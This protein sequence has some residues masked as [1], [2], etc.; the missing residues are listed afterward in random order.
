MAKTSKVVQEEISRWSKEIKRGA[1]TLAI[2]ALLVRG[3]AYGYELVKRLDEHAS[4][5]S[6]E[7]GTVYPLL[8]RMERRGLLR[9]E[10]DHTDPAKPRKYYELTD[11]GAEALRRMCAMWSTLSEGM[12]RIIDGVDLNGTR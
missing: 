9:A 11:G 4:F 1:V 10:W 3:K 7:Q 8:R 6:T 12:N 2:M 5:L